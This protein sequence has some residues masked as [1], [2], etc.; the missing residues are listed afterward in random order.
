M[1]L[2]AMGL[3]SSKTI[4][5][6]RLGG[7]KEGS[8]TSLAQSSTVEAGKGQESGKQKHKRQDFLIKFRFVPKLA[9]VL[10]NI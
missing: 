2:L 3:S 8:C 4:E 10:K 5:T 9:C 7:W 1:P 6:E